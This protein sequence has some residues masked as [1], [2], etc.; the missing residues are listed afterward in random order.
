MNKKVKLFEVPGN[1]ITGY[2][3]EN[4]L[5]DKNGRP[6][7]LSHKMVNA[8]KGTFNDIVKL[9]GNNLNIDEHS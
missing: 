3:I 7:P 6:Y 9:S 1:M 4:T 8:K 5:I 2:R